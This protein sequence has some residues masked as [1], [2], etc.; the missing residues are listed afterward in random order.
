MVGSGIVVH[1]WLVGNTEVSAYSLPVAG[2]SGCLYV[3]ATYRP[4]N[5]PNIVYHFKQVILS[6]VSH[7][8]GG[9]CSLRTSNAGRKIDFLGAS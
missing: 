8:L 6:E 1:S 7:V 4:A 2:S 3:P 9:R 5:Y